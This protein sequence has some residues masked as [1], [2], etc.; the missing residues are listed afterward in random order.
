MR[1]VYSAILLSGLIPLTSCSV[2][3]W[4]DTATPLRSPPSPS[5]ASKD[6]PPDLRVPF[7][8][9]VL[10]SPRKLQ[11]ERSYPQSITQ[12]ALV[13]NEKGLNWQMSFPPRRYAYTGVVLRKALN[14]APHKDRMNL[15][16]RLQ[17]ASIARFLSVALLDQPETGQPALA[18]VPLASFAPKNDDGWQTVKVPLSA[19][20]PGEVLD[21]DPD[22]HELGAVPHPDADRPL[23]WTQIREIRF[24]S[25]GANIPARQIAVRDLRVQRQ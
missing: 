23:D 19:F 11:S 24:I 20:P 9:E 2:A 10:D 17:P 1:A 14:L 25:P 4:V 7:R 16:F 15:V 22:V 8:I 6:A 21:A 5:S 12:Q 3:K 13:W 18:D